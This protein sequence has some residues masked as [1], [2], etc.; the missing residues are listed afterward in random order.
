MRRES[1]TE[2]RTGGVRDAVARLAAKEPERVAS[3]RVLRHVCSI[4]QAAV[5]KLLPTTK[6]GNGDNGDTRTHT[7]RQAHAR[8]GAAQTGRAQGQ[9]LTAAD[10]R[11]THWFI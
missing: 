6:R 7:R 10:C 3:L 8:A 1:K 9:C 2:R 4:H 11:R 5:N